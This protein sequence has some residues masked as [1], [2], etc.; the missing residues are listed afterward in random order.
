MILVSGLV[1]LETTAKVDGFPIN[2]TPV[3]YPFFGVNST[4]SGVGY[5]VAK[6]LLTLGDDIEFLTLLGDDIAGQVALQEFQSLG[7]DT[8]KILPLLDATPQS[9]ILYDGTG[10]RQINVDLKSIQETRYPAD[11]FEEALNRCD[12]AVLCNINFT[13]PF[14]ARAREVG[15]IVATDVHSVS[16]V[17]DDYNRDY[18]ANANILFLSHENLPASPEAFTRQL[19]DTYHNDIVVIGCGGSG[20]LMAVRADNSVEHYPAV[21]TRPVVNT[22]GAGDALFSAF[23]HEYHLHQDPFLAIR[24]ALVFASYKIGETGAAQGFLTAGALTRLYEGVS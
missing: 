6:A 14:L 21:Y 19:I 9:V 24:K 11:T 10:Q 20:A 5:N 7:L 15:K 4:V 1:N 12:L 8:G 16:S 18:M 17:E 23:V 2:Y 3:R 22:I 13:R